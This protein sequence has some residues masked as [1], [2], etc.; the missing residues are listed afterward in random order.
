MSSRCGVD[1]V[2]GRASPFKGQRIK[3]AKRSF[4]TSSYLDVFE[5]NAYPKQINGG[6]FMKEHEKDSSSQ[7]Q[8]HVQKMV[9]ISCMHKYAYMH[10]HLFEVETPGFQ[11]FRTQVN[12]NF[13]LSSLEE[14]KLQETI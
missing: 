2:F 14:G 9:Y 12:E 7:W 10:K 6:V 8:R 4:I 13:N 3:S 5:R 11:Y 1:G